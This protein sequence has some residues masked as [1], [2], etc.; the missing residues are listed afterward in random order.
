MQ[1]VK[2]SY[3]LQ[4]MAMDQSCIM[5][6]CLQLARS[7]ALHSTLF[8]SFPI[9]YL[10]VIHINGNVAF[11]SIIWVWLK[12]VNARHE[13]ML[14]KSFQNVGYDSGYIFICHFVIYHLLNDKVAAKWCCFFPSPFFHITRGIVKISKTA[15][16]YQISLIL[17]SSFTY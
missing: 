1:H 17:K 11:I 15:V 5:R 8:L 6:L 3:M 14:L 4:C 9:I 16:I 7:N 2:K 12:S 10:C 13:S